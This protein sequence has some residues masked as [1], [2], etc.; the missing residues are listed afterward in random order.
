MA[1][2]KTFKLSGLMICSLYIK[3]HEFTRR[4][5]QFRI[6]RTLKRLFIIINCFL[7]VPTFLCLL[8]F[9]HLFIFLLLQ[10]IQYKK[11]VY[12]ET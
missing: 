9:F 2:K 8:L 4:Q 7:F 11:G 5:T 3:D 6:L 12:T 10:A 1:V